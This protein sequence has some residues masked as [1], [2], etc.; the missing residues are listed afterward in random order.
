MARGAASSRN[1][2]LVV[3]LVSLMAANVPPN[4]AGET[5]K[6]VHSPSLEETPESGALIAFLCSP[7]MGYV[8]GQSYVVDGGMLLTTAQTR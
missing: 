3:V 5:R 7:E 1:A 6:H 4:Q 2:G 8:T